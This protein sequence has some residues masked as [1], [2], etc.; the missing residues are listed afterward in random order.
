M[1]MR[2]LDVHASQK[3]SYCVPLWLRD[4]QI[5]LSTARVKG[6]IAPCLE[7]RTD[8]IAVVGFGPSLKDTWERI[9]Q[10]K[11]V[12]SCSG[13]HRFLVERGIIPTWHVEVDP[14]AHKVALLGPPH[15][16]VEYLIASACHP[17][18]FDHLE[19]FRVSLW[20]VFDAS[21]DGRRMLPQGDWAVTGGCD[22]GMRAMTIAAF[23]G[24][25]DMHIFGLDG[26]ATGPDANRHAGEHPNGKQAY[27]TCDY[28]GVTYYTT[29]AMLEA[30]RQT[31]HELNQMPKV[32]AT[33]HG[34][35]LIQAMARRYE[36]KPV[37]TPAAF[38]NIVGFQKP[39]LISVEYMELNAR[40][41]HD[42]LGYGVG[43]GKHADT[44][45]KLK[46]ATKAS[47]VLDYGA[48]KGYLAKAL[49][50]PIWQY[51]PAIPEIA[52][53]PR[54]AD[55]VI[56]TDVLEHVEPDRLQFVLADLR[57]CVRV[58]GFFV[59]HTGPSTKT[60][61]DGRN[62]HLIQRDRAWW[63]GKLKRHFT[64]GK[65]SQS[66]PLLYV[67]VGPKV[68]PLKPA[69]VVHPVETCQ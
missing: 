60:L 54:P 64:V 24:F 17:K 57:R 21:A 49:D 53:S 68:K 59:I 7:A 22:V 32:Q 39:K 30:A 9:R 2:T 35:G 28:E 3:V 8:P 47:S 36:P 15:P 31:F 16:D 34:D 45:R 14:R 11:Y 29:P 4:E 44:V 1:T 37:A 43:G 23:I 19:G 67:V 69:P 40:L 41:H 25:R 66:G 63:K 62:T 5:K 13:S 65:L 52:E 18:L 50:F 56:C 26:C 51:D 46:E 12:V 33:F 55:L 58:V 27:S 10:F 42:N 61:A 6:R 20:H 38:A 48:G